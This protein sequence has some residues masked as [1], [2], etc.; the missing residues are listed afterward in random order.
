MDRS[1]QGVVSTVGDGRQAH[2]G[3]QEDNKGAGGGGGMG[4][5]RS[6]GKGKHVTPVENG[7]NG[8]GVSGGICARK[9][10]KPH[11]EVVP[12]VAVR[13]LGRVQEDEQVLP[14]VP[15]QGRKPGP[16]GGRQGQMQH[17]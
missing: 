17:F 11:L 14:Q 3:A 15:G 10:L 16:A 8:K 13:V 12:A 4:V 7:Y 2:P 1:H 6:T 9:G 5:Y